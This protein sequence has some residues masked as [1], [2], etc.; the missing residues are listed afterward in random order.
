MNRRKSVDLRRV[1]AV[2]LDSSVLLSYFIGE[3]NAVDLSLVK[4]KCLIPFMALYEL[5]SVLAR[6]GDRAL[7]DRYFGIVRAWDV[8][9]IH[10]TEEMILAASRLRQHY[11]LGTGD[12]FIAAA[13]LCLRIPL[14]TYDSDFQPLSREIMILGL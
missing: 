14:L 6:K 8:P 4:S 2:M 1:P 9:V 7:A 12:A 3:P 5:H 13:S 11:H 10:S